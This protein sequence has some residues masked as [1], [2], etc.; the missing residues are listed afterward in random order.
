ML[1]GVSCPSRGQRLRRDLR[2]EPDK[3]GA[4]QAIDNSAYAWTT[5]PAAGPARGPNQDG[6]PAERGGTMA[7]KSDPIFGFSG[8]LSNPANFWA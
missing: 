2:T 4:D 3:H 8:S 6:T 1:S 5:D 7:R